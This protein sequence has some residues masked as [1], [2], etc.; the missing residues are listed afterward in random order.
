MPVPYTLLGTN[1]VQAGLF[2]AHQDLGSLV[3]FKID[4]LYNHR[5]NNEANAETST[6]F[7]RVLR[8]TTNYTISPVLTFHLPESWT[9]SINGLYGDEKDYLNQP[10]Y[11]GGSL[12]S[13]SDNC[14]CDKVKSWEINSEGALLSLPGGDVRTA[15]WVG[16]RKNSFDEHSLITTSRSLYQEHSYYGFAEIY[17]PLASPESNIPLNN[18]RSSPGFAGVAVTV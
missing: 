18:Y 5:E 9:V 7:L 3:T 16:Y 13:R 15:L 6:I 1:K 2:S 8:S 17:L 10:I 14:Y 4:T 12:A 11:S